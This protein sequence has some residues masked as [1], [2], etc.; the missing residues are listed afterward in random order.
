MRIFLR[1]GRI[2]ISIIMV[3]AIVIQ[4]TGV[5]YQIRIKIY[6]KSN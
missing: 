1:G 3:A 5:F 2:L 4:I 6:Q